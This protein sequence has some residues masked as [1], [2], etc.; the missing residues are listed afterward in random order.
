LLQWPLGWLSDRIDR[1]R[2]LALFA[3][4]AALGGA[5]TAALGPFGQTA[6]VGIAV[7]GGGAF[8]LYPVVIAHL[9]DH[10]RHE[11]IL[12]GNAAL[13]LLHG[14][15]AA[16]GPSLAGAPDRRLARLSVT[17]AP[18]SG[19]PSGYHRRHERT[20]RRPLPLSAPGTLGPGPARRR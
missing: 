20:H 12:P 16:L 2:A 4:I 6:I 9:I 8:A 14:I 7:F 11:Q 18:R 3:A 13:L 1:R 19:P 5:L 15:G 17:R 10:L